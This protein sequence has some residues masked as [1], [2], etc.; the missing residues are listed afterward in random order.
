MATNGSYLN[1]K[2]SC[3][4]IE[5]QEFSVTEIRSHAKRSIANLAPELSTLALFRTPWSFKLTSQMQHSSR[6]LCG[7]AFDIC[8]LQ[9]WL[10]ARHAGFEARI[11]LSATRPLTKAGGAQAV[12]A[13]RRAGV[14]VIETRRCSN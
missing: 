6:C 14:R 5:E 8:V 1:R 7:V 4:R 3:S 2:Q 10:D 12:S 9:A 13:M 11:I